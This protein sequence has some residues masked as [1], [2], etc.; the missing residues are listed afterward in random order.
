M[1]PISGDSLAL[2]ECGGIQ[3]ERQVFNYSTQIGL[4]ENHIIVHGTEQ[5]NPPI[6][7]DIAG[8]SNETGTLIH[9]WGSYSSYYPSQQWLF[10][11]QQI[12]SVYNNMCVGVDKINGPSIGSLVGI[13]PCNSTD[14]LQQWSFNPKSGLISLLSSKSTLC[15]QAGNNTPSCDIPPFSLYPYCNPTMPLSTRLADLISRMSPADMARAMDASIPAIPR[16]GIPSMGSGEALHGAAT[17]CLTVPESNGTGCPT[18]FPCPMALAA[19]FDSNLWSE[20]GLAIG[21]ESRALYNAGA[22][23]IWLF[24]PNINP[25]REPRWGRCQEVSDILQYQVYDYNFSLYISAVVVIITGNF[26]QTLRI[27]YLYL[28]HTTLL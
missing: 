20:I 16:L 12:T 5:S 1:L 13:Y 21:L 4:L 24:A 19:S 8:P 6:V 25:C 11:N 28:I 23:A 14:S 26:Q 2:W 18:S 9:V 17:G 15:I 27:L 22:G 3:P 7:W 10:K